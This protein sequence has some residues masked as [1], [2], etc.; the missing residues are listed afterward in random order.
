MEVLQED[1]TQEIFSDSKDI[2]IRTTELH[3]FIPA[4]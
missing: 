2:S 4:T 3:T 1:N